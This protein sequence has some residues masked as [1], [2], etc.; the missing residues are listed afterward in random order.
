MCRLSY[1]DAMQGSCEELEG[2]V[3]FVRRVST[4][5]TDAA[6]RC[7]AVGVGGNY[8]QAEQPVREVGN[9]C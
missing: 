4:G 3:R 6:M 7:K 8:R 1:A 5:T 2:D 9:V